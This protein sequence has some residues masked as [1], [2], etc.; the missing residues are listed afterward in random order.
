MFKLLSDRNMNQVE[1][2]EDVHVFSENVCIAIVAAAKACIVESKQGSKRRKL[3]PWWTE[4][5]TQVVKSI[6]TF[7]KELKRF[8]EF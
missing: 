3:V 6:N 8:F 1:V 7:L 4:G 5:F 2:M